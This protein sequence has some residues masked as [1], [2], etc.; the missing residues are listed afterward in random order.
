MRLLLD[1]HALLWW[2]LDD[3][4]LP[5]QVRDMIADEANAVVVSAASAW[6]L[7]TK[8][9]MGKLGSVGNALPR[10][11]ELI[12]ADG[13]EHLPMHWQHCLRAGSY[14]SPHRDPF[15]RILVAQA[16]VEPMRLITHDPMLRRYGDTIIEI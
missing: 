9:R 2:W 3:P 16:I 4:K 6:E 10:F 5:Q 12:Q 11:H 8:H 14:D 1:T 13:F 15:D 7:A